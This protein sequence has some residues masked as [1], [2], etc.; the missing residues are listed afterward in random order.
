MTQTTHAGPL[1]GTSILVLEDEAIL[2]LDLALTIEDEGA[3]VEGPLHRLDQTMAFDDLGRLDAAILDVDICGTEV[4]AF[5]DRLRAENVPIIF[6]TGRSELTRLRIRYPEA[7]IVR[8]PSPSRQVV[9]MLRQAVRR[10]DAGSATL[11]LAG[12]AAS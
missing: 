2:A 10:F 4:F 9:T 3:T 8:K 1:S 6:H 12:I 11:G 7:Q 5:A